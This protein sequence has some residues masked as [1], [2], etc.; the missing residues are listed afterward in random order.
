MIVNLSDVF[1][2]RG[3]VENKEVVPEMESYESFQVLSKEPVVLEFANV[4]PDKAKISGKLKMTFD[5]MCDRCARELPLEIE[6][7]IERYVVSPKIATTEDKEECPFMDGYQIDLETLISNEI[8][9]NWPV[10]IL[11]KEDCKGVCPVC[12]QNLNDREC[13]CD[14]FVPDPRMAAIADILERN[15]E[16]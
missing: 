5:A 2:I 3:K 14:R 9:E 6:T 13:G 1:T 4:E 16:V 12:G 10:K 8:L 15:K 7:Q 11:C